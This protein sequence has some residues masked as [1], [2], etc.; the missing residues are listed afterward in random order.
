MRARFTIVADCGT[1]RSRVLV[2]VAVLVRLTAYGR[3]RRTES[4]TVTRSRRAG[5]RC[6]L[7]S[8]AAVVDCAPTGAVTRQ[9]IRQAVRQAVRHAVG[10]VGELET[11]R[12]G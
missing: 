10:Q 9:A 2:R 1:S 12:I 3:F 5:L 8:V 6:P 4:A 7:L 11:R